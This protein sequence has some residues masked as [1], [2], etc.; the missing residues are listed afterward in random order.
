MNRSALLILSIIC[1]ST[2]NSFARKTN[3]HQNHLTI[4]EGLAHNSIECIFKDSEGFVWIGTQY[5]LNRYDGFEIKTYRK[6]YSDSNSLSSN[7]IICIS[8]D[9]D[10]H[11]WIGTNNGLNR[12]N[13]STGEFTRFY[14]T[15][16]YE[17]IPDD[18]I[19]TLKNIKGTLWI[20][21]NEGLARFNYEKN[22]FKRF[23][24]RR[25]DTSF[26]SLIIYDIIETKTGEIYIASN[27]NCLHKLNQSN[28]K[29]IPVYYSRDL[30]LMSNYRKHMVEDQNG[31]IWISAAYH[32]LARFNYK[33]KHS[34]ILTPQN[35]SL[36]TVLLNGKLKLSPDN[37][38]W[39][40]S[41][42]F[43]IIVYDISGNKF[44]SVQE[45]I[46]NSNI[47]LNNK[48][49]S[50]L[51]DNQNIIWLGSF[52][53]G[54]T[55]LDPNPQ[56]FTTL[57]TKKSNNGALSGNSV[58][59]IFEDSK[60]NIWVGTDGDGLFKFDTTGNLTQFKHKPSDINSL[61]A[62]RIVCINE[63]NEGNIL[64]GSY[65][66]GFITYNPTSKK[67]T[68]YAPG[69]SER[70]VS[71]H[72]VWTI[73]RESARKVWL[74]LLGNGI[75]LYN[76]QEN[77]FTNLGPYS[78]KSISVNN[79][80]INS[81]MKDK[82][83]DIWFGTEGAGVNY[84]K[85]DAQQMSYS[86]PPPNSDKL[87]E[88]VVRVI[89]Q[90]SNGII[91][92]ATGDGGLSRYDKDSGDFKYLPLT[93]TKSNVVLSIIEDGNKNLWLG[94]GNGLIQFNL[95]TE[96]FRHYT[97]ND[98]LQG[99]MCNRNSMIRLRN[100]NILIGTT[101]GLSLFNPDRL[102]TN[103][104]TPKA[105]LSKLRI[106]NKPVHINDTINGRIVL[107][108]H[109]SATED[110]TLKPKD[111]TFSIEFAAINHTLP[112]LGKFKYKLVGF[113][114][115]WNIS[116]VDRRYATYTNLDPGKY[117]FKVIASNS[118]GIWSDYE[119]S[120]NI[121]VLPTFWRTVW[122]KSILFVVLFILFLT[123]YK[124]LLAEREKQYKREK[125]A[126]EKK[127]IHLEKEKLEA[128][129]NNQTFNVI[130]RN[131]TLVALRRRLSILTKR[132][133]KKNEETLLDIIAQ[134]NKELK[135]EKDW[136]HIEPRLDKVY[137]NFMTTLKHKHNDLTISEL[138]IAAYVRMGLSTKEISEI[139][140]KT[141]KAVENDRY[142]L[143]KK[144]D[145]TS[146]SSLKKYLLDLS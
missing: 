116:N 93:G 132:V 4:D 2:L 20:G 50:I 114:D 60:G 146:N 86:L 110:L 75:D 47:V 27:N 24:P 140:Q 124:Y 122:F 13:K 141:T 135:E 80:N 77:T 26:S 38:L 69:Q 90:D 125:E 5:G 113:E 58:L 74:G 95:L 41:D 133:D 102:S 33:T 84:L 23:I 82:D 81:I 44:N 45:E 76:P 87:N 115:D 126:D 22:N 83:G 31:N 14:S 145:I 7:R 106:Q 136:K 18:R 137:N 103:H 65:T 139:M 37:K 49:Y 35:S 51:F 123:I 143:R 94:T 73:Y 32:G 134:I 62:N 88:S 59:G 42:G 97:T 67:F 108:K 16:N 109:L 53:D 72:H 111:K 17:S 71:S 52:I 21:T 1:I 100:G 130:E 10:G 131:K 66:G 68:R 144:L 91:W 98:G 64:L 63:D 99:N 48:V 15:D 89:Y 40:T 142:R 79:V 25:S 121:T 39:L 85:S 36:N 96:K 129:L 105:I 128:E 12:Y 29:F 107:S 117:T 3:Y 6:N 104:F 127:I 101:N 120:I 57:D 55:I 34:E 112:Q 28:N 119:K 19:L 8:E 92:F 30:S 61:S 56:K 9:K 118:D 46:E 78:S 11:L 138:R 43:G 54:V 70:S